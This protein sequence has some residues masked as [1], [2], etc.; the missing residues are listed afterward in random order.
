MTEDQ[1]RALREELRRWRR[2]DDQF[3]YEIVV[4]PSFD[5]AVIAVRLNL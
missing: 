4:V 1:E 5:D 3:R 2:P